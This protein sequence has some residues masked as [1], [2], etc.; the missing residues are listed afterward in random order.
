MNLIKQLLFPLLASLLIVTVA[1]AGGSQKPLNEKENP[2]LIGD[3]DINKR[4]INIYSVEKEIEFGKLLAAEVD[5]RVELV[6]EPVVIE[7]VNRVT[8]NLAI[9]SDSKL[10]VTVKVINSSDINAF[11]LPGGFLYVN[12]GLIDAV[13][14]EAELA[15]ALAHEVAHIAARHSIE[16]I[17]RRDL[18]RWVARSFNLFGGNSKSVRQATDVLTFKFSR[19]AEKEADMLATQ[20]LWKSEYDPQAL[21]SFLEK[22][23][24]REKKSKIPLQNLFRMFEKLAGMTGTAETEA[25]EFKKIYDLDVMVIPTHQPV[26]RVDFDDQIYLAVELLLGQTRGADPGEEAIGHAGQRDP[27]FGIGQRTRVQQC[28]H[29]P[30]RRLAGETHQRQTASDERHV[31]EEEQGLLVPPVEQVHHH[32]GADGREK[33]GAAGAVPA[34]RED[35][36]RHRQGEEDVEHVGVDIP[37]V[38]SGIIGGAERPDRQRVSQLCEPG[39]GESRLRDGSHYQGSRCRLVQ[40]DG[41][42]V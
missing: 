24:E 33:V 39:G 17:S 9:N 11:S 27:P 36:R 3:R 22:L 28:E 42:A 1:R 18:V 31:D 7:L 34:D 16:K 30:E 2:N 8:Q 12:R 13:D 15:G 14:N 5:K 19:D 26:R 35:E 20:Y 41:D 32:A 40:K 37:Q 25:E 10:L 4:Q 38:A 6:K 29:Q 21:I 23:K